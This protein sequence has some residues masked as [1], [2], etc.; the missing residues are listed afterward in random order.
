MKLAF[1]LLLIFSSSLFANEKCHTVRAAFDIGSG[2]TKMK[3]A[4][5]DKC[6][7]KIIKILMDDQAKVDYK[8]DL[9][10][11]SDES[12]SSNIQKEGIT[13]INNL[14]K[15]AQKLGAKEFFAVTTSAVRTATNGVSF[16]K[17]LV[18]ETGIDIHIISQIEEAKLGFIA[19]TAISPKPI[20]N[21]VVWD[22][23]GGSMQITSRPDKK[24]H[25]YEGKIASVSFKNHLVKDIQKKE[26]KTPNPISQKD[27]LEATHDARVVAKFA[28]A[29]ELKQ[30]LKKKGNIVIGIGGV[31]AY[32]LGGQM[33]VKDKGFYTPKMLDETIKKNLGKKDDEIKSDFASTE[34]SNLIL[35][36]AFMDE[37]EIEKIMIGKINLADG[38]LI[39]GNELFN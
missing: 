9:Q 7:Q 1:L 38:L 32:S 11:S 16:I 22:I 14:K 4:E 18:K 23:G 19:A 2:A 6:Q 21:T 8:E 26:A 34:I 5:V 30:E 29:S 17:R 33:Q 10:K 13:A 25:I 15:K 37:L 28:V 20:Q 27:F 36:K 24:F 3:V 12:L 31:H 35:V 39:S